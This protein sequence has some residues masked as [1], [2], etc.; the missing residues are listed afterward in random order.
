MASGQ[1]YLPTVSTKVL[2]LSPGESLVNQ[3]T[4]RIAPDGG[5]VVIRLK[6]D[7]SAYVVPPGPTAAEGTTK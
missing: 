2:Y 7:S 4:Q 3:D 6:P 5:A 1:Q